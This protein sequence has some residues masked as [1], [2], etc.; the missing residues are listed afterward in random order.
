MTRPTP[1]FTARVLA[2]LAP[3]TFAACATVSNEEVTADV[4]ATVSARLEQTVD[5][6]ASTP[7]DA[8]VRMAIDRMLDDQL[9][10]DEAVAIALINNRD[11]RATLERT[12]VARADLIQAGL[13]E[14]PVFGI[15]VLDGDVASIREYEVFQELLSLF[16]LSARKHMAGKALQQARL[17]VAQSALN[18][19]AEVKQT[20]YGLL[21]D[22][23]SIQLYS[24]VLDATEA[25][26]VLT[27]RQYQASCQDHAN[28]EHV[29]FVCISCS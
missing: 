5:W 24:Q 22:K 28:D 9:T 26:A 8:S 29:P 7:E 12:G 16:T 3:F 14:N 6:N 1:G 2:L 4:S 17:E 27:S 21:A 10:I 25:A 20:Y 19:A 15:T 18:L 11:M 23:Q 13:L